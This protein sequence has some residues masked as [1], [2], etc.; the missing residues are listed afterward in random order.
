MYTFLS[1][2]GTALLL[3]GLWFIGLKKRWAF[4]FTF[5][6]ELLI[7]LYSVHIR[8]WSIAFIGATFSFLAARNWIL[9]GKQ[10]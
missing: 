7:L 5:F 1:W 9:W 2:I 6:G 4:I 8:A 3:I 10:N